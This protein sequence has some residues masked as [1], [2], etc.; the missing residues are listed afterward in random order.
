M[1]IDAI[2]GCDR[3]IESGNVPPRVTSKKTIGLAEAIVGVKAISVVGI[4]GQSF[5][6]GGFD[7]VM[8][9]G[10]ITEP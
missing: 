10:I 3:S 6:L 9:L 8:V 7:L 1:D 5:V 4:P 2:S